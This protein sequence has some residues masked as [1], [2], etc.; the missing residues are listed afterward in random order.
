MGNCSFNFHQT[1][2]KNSKLFPLWSVWLRDDLILHLLNVNKSSSWNL[3]NGMLSIRSQLNSFAD[4]QTH[5]RAH[6][7]HFMDMNAIQ[8]FSISE[9]SILHTSFELP[10]NG[11]KLLK[12]HSPGWCIS[13]WCAVITQVGNEK[14]LALALT[15]HYILMA[16]VEISVWLPWNCDSIDMLSN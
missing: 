5:L 7:K 8:C 9:P 14:W 4:R 16:K 15:L 1:K 12:T 13:E 2:R 3:Q 10:C 11:S 6:Y